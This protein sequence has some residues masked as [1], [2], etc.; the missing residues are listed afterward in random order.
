[1]DVELGQPFERKKCQR[2]ALTMNTF[3][4]YSDRHFNQD[5]AFTLRGMSSRLAV[6]GQGVQL[7]NSARLLLSGKVRYRAYGETASP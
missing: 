6:L 4:H 1:M 7:G 2:A 5:R 3:F